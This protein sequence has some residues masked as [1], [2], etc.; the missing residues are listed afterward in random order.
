MSY[1]SYQTYCTVQE[2]KEGAKER[3]RGLLKSPLTLSR[4]SNKRRLR[5]LGRQRKISRHYVPLIK[6]KKIGNKS[7]NIN[8]S[9]NPQNKGGSSYR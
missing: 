9:F 2:R 6:D 3:V 5:K 1:Y 8:L 4:S 7:Q